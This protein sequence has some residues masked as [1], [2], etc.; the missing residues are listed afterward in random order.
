MNID[1]SPATNGTAA[2]PLFQSHTSP[3]EPSPQE[4]TQ[5]RA[6]SQGHIKRPMNAFM[7]WSR[8][9]RRKIASNNPRLHNSEISKQLGGEWKS[10][11]ESEKRP[12]IDEAKRLRLQHM[13]D[14]PNYKYRPRRRPKSSGGNICKRR[15]ASSNQRTNSSSAYPSFSY[16]HPMETFG[17]GLRAATPRLTLSTLL[18]PPTQCLPTLD[19]TGEHQ[20]SFRDFL[21][22][23]RHITLPESSFYPGTIK[24]FHCNIC[25][26]KTHASGDKESVDTTTAYLLTCSTTRESLS[27]APT[28]KYIQTNIVANTEGSQPASQE[29]T[30]VLDLKMHSLFLNNLIT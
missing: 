13:C 4:D 10:L 18:G 16:V 6:S 19:T 29:I 28:G 17:R 26:G 22:H 15:A 24:H 25:E 9:Q 1:V 11:S 12:F 21:P 23:L 7:V 14:H 2:Q 27:S 20:D 3:L 30:S 8:I 5:Q